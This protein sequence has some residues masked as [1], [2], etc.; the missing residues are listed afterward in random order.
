MHELDEAID[1]LKHQ[2]TADWNRNLTEALN[3]Q[4]KGIRQLAPEISEDKAQDALAILLDLHFF[5]H[6]GDC[7]SL[8]D[9]KDAI[10]FT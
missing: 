2:G 9:V 6:M 4:I 1:A 3:R 8:A 5:N 10:D 7:E